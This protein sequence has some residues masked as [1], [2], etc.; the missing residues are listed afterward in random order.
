MDKNKKITLWNRFTENILTHTKIDFIGVRKTFYI[1][2]GTLIFIGIVSLF[3][4]GLGYGIDF[5][6][7]RT[8][9]VRFD[10]DVHTDNIRKALLAEYGQEPEVKT[11][12]K[13]NQIKITTSFMI[14]DASPKVDSI[15][16]SKLYKGLNPLFKAKISE[17]D[18]LAHSA[19]KEYGKMSSQK[20]QPTIAYS[21]L[22]KAYY[23]VFFT[24]IIIFVYIL[25]R[26]RKWQWGLGAVVSLF[27]D[28]FIVITLF[29]VL[30]GFLPF[31][32]DIDQH[33][34]AAILTIIGYSIMDSVIIFDRIRE[35]QSL[36]PKRLLKDNM[37]AAIN[38]T[39]GRTLNTSGIT[40]MVLLAM[41]IFGGEV[42]RGFTF[43]LLVGV[44]V[45]T[46]SSI[47]NATPIAYDFIIWQ[48]NRKENKLKTLEKK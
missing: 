30:H 8:F 15:V 19:K 7:G 26:F 47:L 23:A 20:V 46:Y 27:H 25:I 9:V 35:Y 12:G 6:G 37:N 22:V 48:Q 18:F 34:I 40:F 10:Q 21:L 32:L 38:S 24:L 42:I 3:T 16:E 31:S 11:F 5:Q 36:F 39:L 41:F 45:G 28:T 4:R 13:N 44:A 33:F 2:S 1:I 14:N 29:S 43:A 17:T